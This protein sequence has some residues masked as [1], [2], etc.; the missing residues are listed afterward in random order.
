METLK[1]RLY[2]IVV[3]MGAEDIAAIDAPRI[4]RL[5]AERRHFGFTRTVTDATLDR[6]AAVNNAYFS[7]ALIV[8]PAS[9]ERPRCQCWGSNWL[10]R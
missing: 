5:L 10:A 1:C 2:W 8:D 4:R 7:Q 3:R 9:P 6:Y